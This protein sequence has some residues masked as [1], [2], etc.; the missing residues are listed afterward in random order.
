MGKPRRNTYPTFT[1][2][3]IANDSRHASHFTLTGKTTRN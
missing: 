3:R 2:G 1:D